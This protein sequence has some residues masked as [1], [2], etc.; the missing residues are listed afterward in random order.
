MLLHLACLK[1]YFLKVLQKL[2]EFVQVKSPAQGWSGQNED[3]CPSINKSML[4]PM[5]RWEYVPK[6]SF[7]CKCF[8]NCDHL[9]P[10]QGPFIKNVGIESGE[11][12]KMDRNLPTDSFKICRNGGRGVKKIKNKCRRL[13]WTTPQLMPK[14]TCGNC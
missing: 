2:S 9:P 6:A 11:G 1:R 4:Q 10:P 12:S 3:I 13:L 8:P 14:V 5:Y 7:L